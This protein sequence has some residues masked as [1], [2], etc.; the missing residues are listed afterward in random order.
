[1]STDIVRAGPLVL[2]RGEGPYLFDTHGRRFLDGLSSLFC[3]QLG[4]SYGAEMATAAQAQLERAAFGGGHA[5]G[6]GERL[7]AL[8]GFG[9][10]IVVGC[11]S[12]AVEAAWKLVR[13]HHVANGEPAR[14][15]A[16]ARQA[17]YHGETLGALALTGVPALKAPFGTPAIP[18]RHVSNTAG[19]EPTQTYLAEMEAA[20]LAEGP[21]TVAMVI[22]EPVQNS[23]GCLVPPGGYWVGLRELCDRYGILLVADEAVTGCGRLGEW[24]GGSRFGARPDLVV[25]AKSLASAYAPIGAV[26]A[27]GHVVAGLHEHDRA[28]VHGLVS[29][30]HPLAAAIALRNLELFERDGVLENVRANAGHLRERMGGLR[31]LPIV[32]DVR[33][34]GFLW[35]AEL[36]GAAER[37]RL[38]RQLLPARL[39]EAGLLAQAD[40][41]GAP[42]V[43]L[44][45]PLIADRAF[46]DDMVDRL[47]TVLASYA[48]SA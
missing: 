42:V 16:I 6:L 48:T 11:G 29:R 33:G 40:D 14:R 5:T 28:L 25:L 39:L 12:E 9:R 13:L 47:G 8:T 27:G 30:G 45:P 19:G 34:D 10:A 35:A 22:A 21:D 36:G 46:L 20:I 41:R 26:L 37:E 17:A 32:S 23:G 4:Y 7:C 15:K 38:I 44:A 43:Q 18:V 2:D 31:E 1:M 24:L 3:A